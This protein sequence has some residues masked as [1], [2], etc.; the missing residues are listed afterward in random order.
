M[1]GLATSVS[2]ATGTW[3]SA[4]S[5]PIVLK[6]KMVAT[7]IPGGPLGFFDVDPTTSPFI[8]SSVAAALAL[9]STSA[10]DASAVSS[11][12][13]GPALSMITNDTTAGPDDPSLRM[14]VTAPLVYNSM[15]RLTRANQKALGLLPGL[16]GGLVGAD[17]TIVLNSIYFPIMDFDPGDGI[18]SGKIDMTAVLTHELAHGMGFIS[19]VDHIDYASSDGAGHDGP[20]VGHDYSDETI[21]TVLDLFRYSADSTGLVDQPL[22]GRCSIGPP[23]RAICSATIRICR[24]TAA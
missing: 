2:I 22:A 9:D 8:Y 3:E 15:L 11:L 6:F 18:D 16:D 1:S 10:H 19:G 17:G 7:A 13:P 23:A 12:Q 21:F 4:F 5:D 20:D 24:T 14:H